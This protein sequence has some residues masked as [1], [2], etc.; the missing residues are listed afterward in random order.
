MDEAHRMEYLRERYSS[1]ELLEELD[2][3]LEAQGTEIPRGGMKAVLDYLREGWAV[4][5]LPSE[6]AE[7]FNVT[8]ANGQTVFMLAAELRRRLADQDNRTQQEGT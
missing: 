2:R 1:D 8:I 5:A 4:L 3:R 6:L 7:Q